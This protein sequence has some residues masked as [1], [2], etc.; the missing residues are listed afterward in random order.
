MPRSPYPVKRS[1]TP[2]ARFGPA[3]CISQVS[4][5]KKKHLWG[6]ERV[7]KIRWEENGKEVKVKV[8]S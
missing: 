3:E 7:I 1:E 5:V 6:D 4:K 2:V 8:R